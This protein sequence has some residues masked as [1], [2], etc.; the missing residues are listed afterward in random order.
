MKQTKYPSS[1]FFDPMPESVTR[2]ARD[3]EIRRAIATGSPHPRFL[4]RPAKH[5]EI[6]EATR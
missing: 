1:L 5:S 6:L 3:D 4:T 2:E